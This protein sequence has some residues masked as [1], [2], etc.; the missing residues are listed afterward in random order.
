MPE[1]LPHRHRAPNTTPSAISPTCPTG[2]TNPT[3]R[4]QWTRWTQ[5]HQKAAHRNRRTGY[6]QTSS[7]RALHFPGIQAAISGL[8]GPVKKRAGTGRHPNRKCPVPGSNRIRGGRN[9]NRI[10]RQFAD[11]VEEGHQSHPESSRGCRRSNLLAEKPLS[12]QMA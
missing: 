7:Y 11:K 9:Q 3:K 4:E 5:L 12:G 2:P 6:C 10:F 8:F 1:N